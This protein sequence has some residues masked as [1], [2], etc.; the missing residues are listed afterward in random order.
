[1]STLTRLA[2]IGAGGVLV[3]S[4]GHFVFRYVEILGELLPVVHCAW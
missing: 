3:L 2:L 4:L 1:M